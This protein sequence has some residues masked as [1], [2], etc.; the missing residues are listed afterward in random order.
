MLLAG[1]VDQ[2]CGVAALPQ[3]LVSCRALAVT[4]PESM[5][6]D[7]RS[8]PFTT[9]PLSKDYDLIIIVSDFYIFLV[10][11]IDIKIFLV[12]KMYYGKLA[13][14]RAQGDKSSKN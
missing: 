6:A 13:K 4:S 9:Y 5:I 7:V 2:E 1:S 14:R 12:L 10:I 8:H 3:L 11:L